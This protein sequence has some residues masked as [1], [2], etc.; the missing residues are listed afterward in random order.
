[1]YYVII[2]V[3]FTN[4]EG[5]HDIQNISVNSFHPGEISVTGD[6]INGSSARDV[7]III[8]SDSRG[9]V[10]CILRF[11]TNAQDKLTTAVSGLP[12]GLYI[13]SVFVVADNGLPFN[14]SATTLKIVSV[15]ERGECGKQSHTCTL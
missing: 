8:Y 1:M 6:F 9:D 12:S 11:P 7:L 3:Y 14:N 5:T 4:F 2:I 10:Y 13:V 15:R